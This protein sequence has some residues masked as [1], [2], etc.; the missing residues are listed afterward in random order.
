MIRRENDSVKI[1]VSSDPIFNSL[2][3]DRI[4]S[5]EFLAG[6]GKFISVNP[7][8]TQITQ[9]ILNQIIMYGSVMDINLD[10]FE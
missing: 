9:D 1:F 3:N 10:S 6:I 4:L 8:K 2:I 5:Q 7:S